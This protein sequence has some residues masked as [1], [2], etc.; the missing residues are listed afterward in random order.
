MNVPELGNM[1]DITTNNLFNF[2]L[3]I[4]EN[5]NE[6][7]SQNNRESYNPDKRIKES[8]ISEEKKKENNKESLEKENGS[9]IKNKVDGLAREKDVADDLKKTYPSEKGYQIVSEAYLRDNKGNIVKDTEKN[10]ARRVDFVVLKDNEVIDSIEVTSKTADKTEQSA[11][12]DRI[13]AAGGNFIRD[14]SGNLVQIP[15]NVK[16]RIERRD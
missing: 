6:Y 13:R 2:D 16:T 5:Q 14:D 10:E 4:T 12:E 3:R 15:S 11:K 8:K 7:D 9:P 1:S